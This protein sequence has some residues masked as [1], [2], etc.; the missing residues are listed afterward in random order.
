[1]RFLVAVSLGSVLLIASITFPKLTGRVVDEAGILSPNTK[2]ELV[3]LIR[4][5]EKKSSNQIVVVTL[6]SLQGQSISDYGYQLGRHWGIGQK[7]KDNGVLL[8][9]APNE[10]KVRIEVGYGLESRLTDALSSMI[11]HNDILPYFKRGDYDG[12]ILK[13][14]RSIIK[15]IGGTYKV[16]KDKKSRKSVSSYAPIIFFAFIFFIMV[17]Q[18]LIANTKYKSYAQRAIPASFAAFFIYVL[19]GFLIAAIIAF[20]ALLFILDGVS[21]GNDNTTHFIGGGF[22]DFDSGDSF[23]SF[24]GGFS[25]GGGSFGGGGASGSW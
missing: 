12:G 22:N 5:S 20:I 14:V 25:G 4:K 17:T 6:K 2:L 7:G 13:G 24:G 1:M 15:A 21:S 3:K 11:I 16:K 8:I 18:N 10:R 9:V 23:G 19:T